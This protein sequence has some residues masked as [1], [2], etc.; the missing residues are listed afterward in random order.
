[1]DA[2]RREKGLS[3][4]ADIT[5]YYEN[6]VAIVIPVEASFPSQY[7]VLETGK[8]YEIV[9]SSWGMVQRH[10]RGAKF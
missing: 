7:E 10:D 1:M 3:E 2:W 4:D 9:R 5:D 8:D 6:D